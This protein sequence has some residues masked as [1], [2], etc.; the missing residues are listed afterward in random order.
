MIEPKFAL[1]NDVSITA[2]GPANT[3]IIVAGNPIPLQ[4]TIINYGLNA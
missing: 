3:N 2:V 4:A 1:N